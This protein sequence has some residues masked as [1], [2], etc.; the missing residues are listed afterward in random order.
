MKEFNISASQQD[1][2][3][4]FVSLA[5]I[6]CCFLSMLLIFVPKVIEVINN[7]T[8]KYEN[9]SNTDTGVSKEDEE[10]YQKLLTENDELQRLIA[11]VRRG[12]QIVHKRSQLNLHSHSTP[13]ERR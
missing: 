4:A 1:A 13:L 11:G 8:D 7:P 10:R 6:F 9:K 2:S 5:V 3:F 12:N